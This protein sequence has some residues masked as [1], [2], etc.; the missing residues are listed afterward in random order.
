MASRLREQTAALMHLAVAGQNA[1]LDMASIKRIY[2]T[3]KHSFTYLANAI[4][5]DRSIPVI[6]CTLTLILFG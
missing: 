5:S 6:F 2:P 3:T 4:K 1:G